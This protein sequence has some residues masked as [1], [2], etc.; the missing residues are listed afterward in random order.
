M[1][2]IESFNKELKAARN[3][4]ATAQ[5]NVALAYFQAKGTQRDNHKGIFYLQKAL[6]QNSIDALWFMG[7]LKLKSSKTQQEI[8]Q[9]LE[10]FLK[11]TTLS[12]SNKQ[13]VSAYIQIAKTYQHQLND[14][15]K[16]AL[17]YQKSFYIDGIHFKKQYIQEISQYIK[18][19]LKTPQEKILFA[20]ESGDLNYASQHFQDLH[21]IDTFLIHNLYTTESARYKVDLTPLMIAIEHK[22]L[23][24]VQELIEN[25]ADINLINSRGE[26]ALLMALRLKLFNFAQQLIDMGADVYVADVSGN[27]TL[28]YAI[29]LSQKQLALKII[30]MKDYPLNRWFDGIVFNKKEPYLYAEYITKSK[31]SNKTF[32]YL[33]L[34]TKYN[35]IEVIRALLLHGVQIDQKTKTPLPLDALAIA[36]RFASYDAYNTLLKHGADKYQVY[37]NKKPEGNYGLYYWGGLAEKYTLL[38]FLLINTNINEK[39][40]DNLLADPQAKFY[41]EN[42]SKYLL[43]YLKNIQKAAP[44]DNLEIYKKVIEFLQPYF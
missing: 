8:L 42:E 19:N 36:A 26:S 1:E 4:S 10:Y 17:F 29:R 7:S 35:Q 22:N 32:N 11:I 43:V 34:A 2:D 41:G 28:S 5:Y 20:F 16:A 44:K 3:G 6:K 23:S 38:S 40:I 33:H 14:P 9:A 12:P 39:L 30:A 18:K 31:A 37:I 21:N 13:K 24:L 25:G 27:T 15:Y